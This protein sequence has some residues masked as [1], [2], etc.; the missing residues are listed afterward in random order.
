MRVN[1]SSLLSNKT[2]ILFLTKHLGWPKYKYTE[3]VVDFFNNP[4][5]VLVKGGRLYFFE[6]EDKKQIEKFFSMSGRN[7]KEFLKQLQTK[8]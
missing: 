6:L 4:I 8:E 1:T 5:G 2:L 3:V 7:R